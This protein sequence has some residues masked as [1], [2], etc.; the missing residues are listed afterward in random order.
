MKRIG[1]AIV[2]YVALMS[3]VAPAEAAWTDWPGVSQIVKIGSCLLQ[4]VG[5]IT[6]SLTV[7]ATNFVVDTATIVRDCLS[8]VVSVV[9]PG[10]DAPLPPHEAPSL[11][12]PTP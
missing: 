2:F 7:H 1:L 4:D 12:E 5:K 8:Y 9:T 3:A 11:A 10:T 6:T